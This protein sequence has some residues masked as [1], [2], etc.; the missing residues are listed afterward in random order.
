MFGEEP[1]FG[2]KIITVDEK[3]RIIIPPYTKREEGEK[4]VLCWDEDL[5]LYKILSI[6]KIVENIKKI[7]EIIEKT[8]EKTKILKYKLNKLNLVRSILICDTVDKQGRYS[9]KDI[10]NKKEKI[11]TIGCYVSLII[12]KLNK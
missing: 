6:N 9:V 3:E 2:Q 4:L 11:L 5:K 10:F 12:D 7:D 1:I 8:S